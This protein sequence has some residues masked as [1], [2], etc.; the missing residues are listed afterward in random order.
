MSQSKEKYIKKLLI[1]HDLRQK[2]LAEHLNVTPQAINN[3]I[4]M[5][6]IEPLLKAIEELR[7]K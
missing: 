3:R 4:K 7:D 5:G 6:R 1:D 2:D